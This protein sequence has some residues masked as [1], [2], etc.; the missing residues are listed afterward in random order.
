M[1]LRF[2]LLTSLI[3]LLYG[4]PMAQIEVSEW[5]LI[6]SLD[7]TASVYSPG[8]MEVRID[9][10]ETDIGEVLT[11]HHV[12][13]QATTVSPNFL[14][15]MSYTLYPPGVI[16]Q[17][18]THLIQDLLRT[19]IDNAILMQNAELIYSAEKP[20][21]DYPGMIWKTRYAD[22]A[23]VM[24]SE[25]YFANDHLYLL[26]VGSLADTPTGEAVEHFFDSFRILNSR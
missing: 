20:F 6:K 17:D 1:F 13:R 26:Q 2:F 11:V 22:N 9:S 23:Y 8:K 14:F 19:T 21:K 10:I 18:S 5:K 7:Q 25:I 12:L 16:S 4:S 24:K 3:L 15:Q